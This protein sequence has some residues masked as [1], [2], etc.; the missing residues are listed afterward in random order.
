MKFVVSP[1]PQ[2]EGTEPAAWNNYYLRK[3]QLVERTALLNTT[4]LF[5][6][7]YQHNCQLLR[8]AE[9]TR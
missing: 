5:R 1:N 7:I 4:G 6:V 3:V 8:R 9:A 2:L